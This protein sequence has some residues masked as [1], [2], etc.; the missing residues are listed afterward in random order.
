MCASGPVALLLVSRPI[1]LCGASLTLWAGAFCSWP[2]VALIL[3][4]WAGSALNLWPSGLAPSVP[5]RLCLRLFSGPPGW[6]PVFLPVCA[7]CRLSVCASCSYSLALWAGALSLSICAACAYSLAFWAGAL[8]S[9]P[10]VLVAPILW[11]SGLAPSVPILFLAVCALS[12]CACC[13]FSLTFWAGPPLV[14]SF[15]CLRLFWHSGLAPSVPVRLCLLRLFS[16]P[17][18]WRPPFLSFFAVCA[19]SVCACCAF[20]L[21]LWA[22]PSVPILLCLRLFWHSGLAISVPIHV[23]LLRLFSGPLGWPPLLL[24]VC[25]LAPSLLPSGLACSVPIRLCLVRLF[26]GP[27]G[28]RILLLSVYARCAGCLALWA[29]ALCSYPFVLVSL[30]LWPLVLARSLFYPFLLV[31]PILWPFVLAC[32]LFIRLCLLCLFFGLLGWRALFLSVCACF[33]YSLALGAGALRSCPFFLFAPCQFVLVAPFLWPSACAC[34]LALW[35]GA[36]CSYPCFCCAYSLALLGWPPLLLSVCALAPILLPSGLPRFVPVRLFL[37]RLFSGPLGWRILLLSVYARSLGWRSVFLPVCACCRLSVCVFCS[38]SLAL[39][40]GVLCSY[41][42][43]LVSPILWPS[44][45]APSVPVRLRVLRLFSGPL[46]W[47]RLFVPV[48]ACFAYSLALCAGAVSFLSVFACC[49]YSLALRAGVLSFYLFVLVVPILW[50]S[51]LACSV[52]FRLCLFRLFSGPRGWRP[53]FLSFFS[54]CA[55]SVCACCA[56]SLALCLRLFTG[57]LGWRSLFL[58]MCF[59]CAYSLALLGWP[60]LLLSVCALAPILLPSGLARSVPVRLF[61][62]RLFSGLL[63]WSPLF[64]S[65]C[66]CCAYSLAL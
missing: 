22:G 57:P 24:S 39:W 11:P 55:L 34:L 48:C 9:C 8:C 13:A 21:A 53:P 49:A 35:A 50:P 44:G 33:A 15:W 2:F 42:F 36:L 5:I 63:G 32:S 46:S 30:I 61:L 16:G 38:Y 6:R 56:F 26:S 17:L 60:P 14:L 59:C 64:L 45:L 1:P 23:F 12:V 43:V 54:V 52:P 25:A 31:A 18:G 62:F 58:S 29:G 37:F 47:R 3:W 19:L 10:F 40:A 66:A 27:L 7:C 65:V 4:P 41:P 28:W 20:S 51:G